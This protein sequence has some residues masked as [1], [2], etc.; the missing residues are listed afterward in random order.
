MRSVGHPVSRRVTKASNI[1]SFAGNTLDTVTAYNSRT[2]NEIILD[3]IPKEVDVHSY[4]ERET[5]V[6][7]LKGWRVNLN[8]ENTTSDPLMVH[9]AL[10]AVARHD[11][12]TTVT[13]TDEFWRNYLNGTRTEDFNAS[14]TGTEYGALKVNNDKYKV[15]HRWKKFIDGTNSTNERSKY[16]MFKRYLK[17]PRQVIYDS[18]EAT[19]GSDS[20]HNM[21]LYL[22][23]WAHKV[24]ENPA[25]ASAS[26]NLQGSL[27]AFWRDVRSY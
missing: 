7:N 1:S 2:L 9:M 10:I 5:D 19:D 8:I 21:R 22:V 24:L 25:A 13:L 4:I 6:I 27:L 11:E 18:T 12:G 17:F 23:H 26:Y 15:I 14:Q 16:W 20:P 3:R